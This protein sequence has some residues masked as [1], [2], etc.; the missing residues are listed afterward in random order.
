MTA[1]GVDK[2]VVD[3]AHRCGELKWSESFAEAASGGNKAVGVAQVVSFHSNSKGGVR[4]GG[5]SSVD[6]RE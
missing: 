3:V 1:G 5:G 6:S 2:R 4:A